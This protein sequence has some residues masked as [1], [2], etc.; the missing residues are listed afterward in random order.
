MWLGPYTKEKSLNDPWGNRYFY[1]YFPK[2]KGYQLYTLGSDHSFGV[3]HQAKDLLS[4]GS[5]KLINPI[6]KQPMD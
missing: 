2:R 5:L 6:P 4:D 1:Q 3:N